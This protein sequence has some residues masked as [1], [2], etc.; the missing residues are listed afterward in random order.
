MIPELRTLDK[1]EKTTKTPDPQWHLRAKDMQRRHED[2]SV[3][4]VS[5][6]ITMELE[7]AM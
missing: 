6:K 2:I 3:K 4:R 1:G 5:Q 7:R